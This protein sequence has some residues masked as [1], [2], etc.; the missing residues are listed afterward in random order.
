MKQFDSEYMLYNPSIK[1]KRIIDPCKFII[2]YS[3]LDNEMCDLGLNKCDV[4]NF[5]DI[6]QQYLMASP[7]ALGGRCGPCPVTAST[8][9]HPLHRCA[10]APARRQP[11]LR[12][13]GFELS[14]CRVAGA[15][16]LR[17]V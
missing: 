10:G 14:W 17:V 6:S 4:I 16:I 5:Y 12:T 2:E 15:S 3:I 9:R 8:F 13:A 1:L 11:L 7:A